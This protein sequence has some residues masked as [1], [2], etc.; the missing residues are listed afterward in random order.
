MS[1]RQAEKMISAKIARAMESFNE[2]MGRIAPF[3]RRPEKVEQDR[4]L[5][6]VSSEQWIQDTQLRERK[7]DQHA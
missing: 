1:Q 6:W 7:N 2:K 4:H 3:I 5:P